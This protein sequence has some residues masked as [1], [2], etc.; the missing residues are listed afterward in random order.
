M[1]QGTRNEGNQNTI[2]R[3]L[4]NMLA[5]SLI[6]HCIITV[7]ENHRKSLIL[8]H[9][10]RSEQS[11][12]FI[13]KFIQKCQKWTMW[14]FH[15]FQTLCNVTCNVCR[16][17]A[18]EKPIFFSYAWIWVQS[19]DQ[20]VLLESID[21]W[22]IGRELAENWGLSPLHECYTKFL[23]NPSLDHW[24]CKTTRNFDPNFGLLPQWR[25]WTKG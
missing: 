19:F 20:E 23:H 1:S 24:R 13:K 12:H 4:H 10:E 9:C 2:F 15:D 11:L 3:F 6:A 8:K 17:S 16:I 7:V 5:V 22:T 21:N 25:I 18:N 14:L